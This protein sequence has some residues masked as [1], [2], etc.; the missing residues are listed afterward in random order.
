MNHDIRVRTI[1]SSNRDYIAIDQDVSYG[2]MYGSSST[3]VE[4]TP[5]EAESFAKEVLRQVEALK[6]KQKT[7]KPFWRV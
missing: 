3:T 7:V 1:K 5:T 2:G 6:A 4:L